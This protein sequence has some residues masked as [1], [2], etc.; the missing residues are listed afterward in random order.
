MCR[1]RR[2]RYR[3]VV[4]GR[5]GS[6]ALRKG[7]TNQAGLKKVQ[8]QGGK[9]RSSDI[10]PDANQIGQRLDPWEG[11][12][13]FAI[14]VLIPIMQTVQVA[15]QDG[16][17]HLRQCGT[18]DGVV[19]VVAGRGQ[20]EE[21]YDGRA[22][23]IVGQEGV[24][25]FELLLVLEETSGSKDSDPTVNGAVAVVGITERKRNV[26]ATECLS[27]PSHALGQWSV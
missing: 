21:R 9:S 25:L 3:V 5:A 8:R 27:D 19:D 23:V 15:L 26:L 13:D 14:R 18:R 6:R 20:G 4:G 12:T 2:L 1:L 11:L 24:G 17:L 7:G 10:N 16:L 22:E